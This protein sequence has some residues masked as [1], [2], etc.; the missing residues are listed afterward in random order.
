MRGSLPGTG[1]QLQGPRRTPQAQPLGSL[2]HLAKPTGRVIV[3]E[4]QRLSPRDRREALA[5][6]K[7]KCSKSWRP[8]SPGSK[9]I[10]AGLLSPAIHPS[11]YI[12]TPLSSEWAS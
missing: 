12:P 7:A 9:A 11:P 5:N 3:E 10:L 8:F 6:F 2:R 4:S 1:T